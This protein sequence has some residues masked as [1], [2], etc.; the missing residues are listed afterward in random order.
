MAE[1]YAAKVSRES[2]SLA[3]PLRVMPDTFTRFVSVQRVREAESAR[4]SGLA[5]KYFAER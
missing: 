5:A 2:H 4:W 1:Y 3:V